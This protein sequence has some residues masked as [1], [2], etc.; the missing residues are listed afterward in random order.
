MVRKPH[1][2]QKSKMAVAHN[3][4]CAN[5]QTSASQQINSSV[6]KWAWQ[7]MQLITYT[8]SWILF[9]QKIVAHQIIIN[10]TRNSSL[11]CRIV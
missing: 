6:I 4:F 10:K 11:K 5:Q 2:E 9:I 3:T 8:E 7:C 1:V